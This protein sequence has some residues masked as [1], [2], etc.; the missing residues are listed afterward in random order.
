VFGPLAIWFL[1]WY[2]D[3]YSGGA[4]VKDR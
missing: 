4:I 3:H 2:R 1:P